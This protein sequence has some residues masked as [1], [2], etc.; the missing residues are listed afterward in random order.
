[1]SVAQLESA[2]Q[3]RTE[4]IN[5]ST[6]LKVS[7]RDAARR[8]KQLRL[9]ETLRTRAEAE[10]RGEDV[11]R[12]KNW[13]WTVEENDEWEKKQRRKARNADF[14]FHGVCCALLLV[15]FFGAPH[16]LLRVFSVCLST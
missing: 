9:A 10:E 14:E 11:E 8:E 1:M 6:K 12:G 13:H 2:R 15:F 3:N 5:E 16:P 4:V 7:V